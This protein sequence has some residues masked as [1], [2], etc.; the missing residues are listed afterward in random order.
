MDKSTSIE[1]RAFAPSAWCQFSETLD[2]PMGVICM[3]MVSP[4]VVALAD[5]NCDDD[6]TNVR[7]LDLTKKR[8]AHADIRVLLEYADHA[9]LRLAEHV[10]EQVLH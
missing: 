2:R 4:G 6:D 1:I 9:S 5:D 8:H 3:C 7:L 10:N